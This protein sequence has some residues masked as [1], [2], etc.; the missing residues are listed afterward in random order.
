MADQVQQER[1]NVMSALDKIKREYNRR[2]FKQFKGKTVKSVD[3][4]AINA[5]RF[6]F[7]DGSSAWIDCDDTRIGIGVI[8]VRSSSETN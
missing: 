4:T 5:V 1:E 2:G 3:T 8:Q 7:T 6:L